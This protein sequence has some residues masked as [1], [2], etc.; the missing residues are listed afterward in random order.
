MSIRIPEPAGVG[1]SADQFPSWR[2]G[3]RGIIHENL[4]TQ[5]RFLTQVVPTGGGKTVCYVASA[6]LYGGRSLILTSTKGLQDQIVG[7]FGSRIAL[8]KGQSAYRCRLAPVTCDHAACKWG[9]PCSLKRTRGC[10]YYEA[11]LKAMDA[12]I[13][14]TNYSFWFSN[15]EDVL[16]K[17]DRLICDEAHASVHHLLDSLSVDL[18][19]DDCNR[20]VR[21]PEGGHGMDTYLAWARILAGEV[22]DRVQDKKRKGDT[23]GPE[24]ARLLRLSAKLERLDMIRPGEWVVEHKGRSLTFD[25]VWPDRFAEGYLFRHI[26]RVLMTSA[27]VTP[28]TLSLLGVQPGD[29]KFTE[30]PSSFPVARRPVYYVPTVRVDHRMT[31]AAMVAW[32]TKIDQIINSRLDCKGIIHAVSYDRSRRILNNSRFRDIMMTHESG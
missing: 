2:D 5:Q 10:P 20:Y 11:I 6:I 7:D 16:G 23:S 25:P 31:T 17:F 30:Y 4:T 9:Y 14:V 26:P 8:V 15:Q 27:T 21:W 18:T 22:R 3:Q 13:V 32:A 1:L 19:K 28:K 12:K 29:M 24:A